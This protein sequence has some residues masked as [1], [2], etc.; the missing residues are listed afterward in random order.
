MSKKRDSSKRSVDM[1]NWF[2][3]YIERK[4]RMHGVSRNEA[5]RHMIV[6]DAIRSGDWPVMKPIKSSTSEAA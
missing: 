1:G 5:L 4:A 3:A 2:W 6:E